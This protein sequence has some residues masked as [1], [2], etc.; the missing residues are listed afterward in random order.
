MVS[1]VYTVV[2]LVACAAMC[3]LGVGTA[4][5][6]PLEDADA[7]QRSERSAN[8]S[9]ITGTARKI[10]MYV[11]NRYLQIL[12]D[13]TVNGTGDTSE[14]S[15]LQRQSVR[16]GQVKIQGVATCIYLCMDSCGILYGSREFAED[17]V[18]NEMIEQHHYNTYSSTKYSNHRRILYLALNRKG[19]PR[20]VQIKAK[21]PLG[22]LSTY[23]RVLTQPVS[24]E[25]VEQLARRLLQQ[26]PGTQHHLRHHQLCPPASKVPLET[27][28]VERCRKRKKRRK[29]RRCREGEED[30]EECHKV[31]E[32]GKRRIIVVR[33]RC[34]EKEG[35]DKAKC[36]HKKLHM[37][38][39][40]RKSRHEMKRL[41][42]HLETPRSQRS[43]EDEEEEEEQE[44]EHDET[45]MED[46]DLTTSDPLL[47]S[48]DK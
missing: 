38:G 40:K 4:P 10:R 42:R 48:N 26:H 13:G 32:E 44:D 24:A 47:D 5:T 31:K 37:I 21:S 18:F 43:E 9:H 45:T 25:E 14:F 46:D 36:Q 20:R 28:D 3:V 29:R 1:A 7:A 11:K 30:N 41:L 19:V 8:L 34:E 39:R 23:T 33:K 16:A 22:K 27:A 12:S 35:E 6:H 15:I 2:V 17:C